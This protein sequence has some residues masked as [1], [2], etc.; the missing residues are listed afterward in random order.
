MKVLDDKDKKILEMLMEDSRRS[1]N[2]ISKAVNLSESTVRKRVIKLKDDGIIEKFTIQLCPEEVESISA[3]LTVIPVTETEIKSLLR[4]MLIIP[5]CT[6]V[7]KMAGQCGVL[8]KLCVPNVN[9]LD[10]IIELFQG[11]SD[12]KNVERVCVVLKPVKSSSPD[13]RLF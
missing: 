9:E 4:E 13:G 10:A 7:Y 2:E 8:V 11:R 3:F 12:V 6:E 5:Q 1:Y